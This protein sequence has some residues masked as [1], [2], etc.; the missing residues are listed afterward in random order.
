MNVN[1]LPGSTHTFMVVPS[2]A[3]FMRLA[4]STFGYPS[5]LSWPAFSTRMSNS[6]SR[7]PGVAVACQFTCRR[8]QSPSDRRSALVARHSAWM[9]TASASSATPIAQVICSSSPLPEGAATPGDDS[10]ERE[11][12]AA[13]S[14]SP[15]GA[16][17]GAG[18]RR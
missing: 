1:A 6:P 2:V 5:A 3:Q 13:P 15:E 8:S 4:G 9:D 7:R 18:D 16:A 14:H 17:S 10:V 11:A 12:S